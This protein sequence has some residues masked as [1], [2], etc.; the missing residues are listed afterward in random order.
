MSQGPTGLSPSTTKIKGDIA[1]GASETS[2]P[3]AIGMLAKNTNPTNVA[4]GQRVEQLGD[5]RGKSIVEVGA[6]RELDTDGQA[7]LSASMAE[8]TVLAQVASTFVDVDQ[9]IITN[10]SA[11]STTITIRDGTGGTIRMVLDI[12][13]P[14]GA[15]IPCKLRQATVNNN[16]TAQSSANVTPLHIFMHGQKNR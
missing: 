3:I 5:I 7:A 12:A 11:S 9:I 1:S 6:P 13:G 10:G 2:N 4:D 16:W 8:T 14:G 15:V